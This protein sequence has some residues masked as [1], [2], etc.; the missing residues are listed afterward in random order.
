MVLILTQP[1]SS[2]QYVSQYTSVYITNY[3][4]SGAKNQTAALVKLTF[5][6]MCMNWQW[7]WLLVIQ[8]I[9]S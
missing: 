2:N 8:W 6:P 9:Q 7:S 4:I 5:L 3:L 1:T